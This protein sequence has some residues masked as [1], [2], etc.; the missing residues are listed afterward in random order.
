MS[1]T[2][3]SAK[4]FFLDVVDLAR[5]SHIW[6]SKEVKEKLES[7]D[8][9]IRADEARKQAERYAACVEA[10]KVGRTVMLDVK[11]DIRSLMGADSM[12]W[13]RLYNAINNISKAIADL[14]AT[15]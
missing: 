15:K 6:M 4:Y 7:R 8:A 14:E 10:A 5:G 13:I 3:Q 12:D 11:D 2:I 9:A 1:D